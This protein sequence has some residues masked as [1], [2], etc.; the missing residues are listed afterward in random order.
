MFVGIMVKV[1]R[2]RVEILVDKRCIFFF[3]K[4]ICGIMY[5]FIG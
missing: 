2:V 4:R 5:F 3:I 1:V